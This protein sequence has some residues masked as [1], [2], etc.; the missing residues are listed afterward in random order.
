MKHS[1]ADF[2]LVIGMAGCLHARPNVL[3][4]IADDFGTDSQS[5]YNP[6][7]GAT[8][9]T[10]TI[11]A[12]A[13]A[14]LRFTN[15]WASPVCSPTRACLL[16]GRHAFRTG[17]GEAV[18]LAAANSL[19]LNELTLPEVITQSAVNGLQ[20]A[21]FG[22]WHLT[23]GGPS[24]T[25]PAPNAIGGWPHY[26]G[27]TGGALT[28]Y[29]SWTKVTNGTSTT[30][31]TYATTDVVNDAIAWIH[32]RTGLG[33]PWLA[34]VAFNAPHTPFHTPP[35]SLHSYGPNPVTNLLKYRAAVQAMDTE[36][37]RLLTAVNPATTT[38]IFM[39]DNGTPGQVAQAPYN[40][41]SAKDT[42]YDGGVRIP[43]IVRGP[44]IAPSTT[45]G[46]LV[47][48][49][50]LFSTQLELAGLTVPSGVTLDS[51]SLMPI[52]TS[53]TSAVRTRLFTDQFDASAPST[54]G[55]AL[56]DDRYKLIRFNT[57]TDAFYD[58]LTDSGEA[59]NLLGGGIAAM[60]AS[61]QAHYYRLR[62]NLGNYT[63]AAPP[64]V[65]QPLHSPSGFALTVTEN[66]GTSQSLWQSTDLDFWSP[67]PNPLRSTAN[68]LTTFTAPPPLPARIFFSVLQEVP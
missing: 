16:T 25:N 54:G 66:T 58:L 62:F 20:S 57:G 10:P 9:P 5:L 39:G 12:L 38:V 61:Q 55:R 52:L 15:A 30:S 4:V 23:A 51:H 49:V 14:G 59:A 1:V 50:D 43:L 26:A 53:Q 29:T 21:C 35:D 22:K 42:L 46:A 19:T 34:W 37:A 33:Q 48:A 68:G 32:A 40:N 18:S 27:A 28:S 56:R 31:T 41:T 6:T 8:A 44:G 24:L 63:T 65:S 45:T 7:P 60:S 47:H 64:A 67:V 11:N 17:V 13:D 2:L 36:M 3:L